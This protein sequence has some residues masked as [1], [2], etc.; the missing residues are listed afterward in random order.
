MNFVAFVIVIAVLLVAVMLV[1]WIKGKVGGVKKC[2]MT[3][4]NL[5]YSGCVQERMGA[6]HSTKS[7]SVDADV[8]RHRYVCSEWVKR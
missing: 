5:A 2:C 7:F 1:L 3:C 4:V 8:L 6:S